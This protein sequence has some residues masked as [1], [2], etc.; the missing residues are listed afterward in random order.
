M[1][2]PGLSFNEWEMIA[3]NASL[4]CP[5]KDSRLPP[6]RVKVK[7]VAK[8]YR[9]YVEHMRLSK[10]FR[11]F[12]CVTSV[13]PVTCIDSVSHIALGLEINL[14]RLDICVVK[15]LKNNV[16]LVF[17]ADYSTNFCYREI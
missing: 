6:K 14:F 7:Q 10:N 5:C 12:S 1:E 3:N 9:D 15:R 4:K 17:V 8:Y 13:K 16:Y 2:L 11:N